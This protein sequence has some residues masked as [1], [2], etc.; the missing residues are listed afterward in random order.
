MFGSL[1]EAFCSIE[2]CRFI[3]F[4]ARNFRF[5]KCFRLHFT[6]LK[7]KLQYISWYKFLNQQIK[8]KNLK[9]SFYYLYYKGDF[10]APLNLDSIQSQ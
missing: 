1:R 5:F 2:F 4:L 10:Y 6:V 3:E 9:D 7:L 8:S